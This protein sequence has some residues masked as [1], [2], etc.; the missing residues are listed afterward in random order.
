MKGSITKAL[1]NNEG[2]TYYEFKLFRKGILEKKISKR[3]NDFVRLHDVRYL[4]Y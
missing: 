4:L 2:V 3:F 1:V